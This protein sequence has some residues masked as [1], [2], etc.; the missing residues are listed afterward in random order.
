MTIIT[1]VKKHYGGY[2]QSW[3]FVQKYAGVCGKVKAN[4]T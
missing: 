2:W 1:T 4:M 3:G